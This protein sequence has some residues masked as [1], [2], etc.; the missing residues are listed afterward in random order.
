MH[1]TTGDSFGTDPIGGQN[2]FRA[3]DPGA[4]FD[5]TQADFSWANAL[6]EEIAN[7]IL[8]FGG[9][10]NASSETVQQMNQA[11][12]KIAAAINAE[13]FTRNANDRI[14]SGVLVRDEM[15]AVNLNFGQTT[16]L[17][18][19]LKMGRG[20]IDGFKLTKSATT[21]ID[22]DPGS[23]EAL[24]Y[25]AF[26]V[27]AAAMTKDLSA[28]WAAGTGNGGRATSVAL[29]DPTWWHVFVIKHTDGT[30]D[31]GFDVALDGSNLLT[32][33]GYTYARRVGSIYYVSA[34]IQAFT[35]IIESDM[36]LW[37]DPVVTAT[38]V[39]VPSPTVT[40]FQM[41]GTVP[42]G[43]EL[44][45]KFFMVGTNAASFD[46]RIWDGPLGATFPGTGCTGF[47][48]GAAAQIRH[49]VD[50]IPDNLGRIY[51]QE[52]VSASDSTLAVGCRGY[53]DKRILA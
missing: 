8:G 45:G 4:A 46:L 29:T 51:G 42:P 5:A 11:Y 13:T 25:D 47:V 23:C 9:S 3:E 21:D 39:I 36:V 35:H 50:I 6:Q 19:L 18:S 2:I 33:S 26:M 41:A 24:G 43:M 37:D 52:I 31:A 1:R 48:G 40:T 30:V 15:N 10:L 20:Y 44:E 16:V 27:L 14:T 17:A 12:T 49:N 38:P 53:R 7:I 22:I 28:V 32:G 34:A